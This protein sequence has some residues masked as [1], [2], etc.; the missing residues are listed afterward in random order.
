MNQTASGESMISR[1]LRNANP[2]VFAAYCIVAAFCTYFCMYAFRK[3]FTAG[4][5]ADTQLGGVDYKI[6]LV[7]TQVAG[8]TLSK[9]IGIK[10]VSELHARYRAIGIAVLIAVAEL[11]LLLF[12]ITPRPYNF[13]WL[14]FN[15]L[16]LGM[17]FGL[18]LGYLEGRRFTEALSAGLCASFIVSSGFVKSV[19]TYLMQECSIS[20]TWMPFVTGYVFIPPLALSVWL[21]A[22]I[23]PPDRH[24]ELLRTRREPM[25]GRARL[26]FLRR[27]WFGLSALLLIILMLTVVRSIRDD[28]AAEIWIQFGYESAPDVF[29]RSE[30]WVAVGVTLINAVVIVIG[31]NRQAFLCSLGIM[32]FGFALAGGS[33]F[34]YLQAGLSPFWFMVLLGLGMYIPYVAFHTTIYER[35]MAAF[36]EPGTIGYLMYLSDALGY[37]GFVLLMVG[38]SYTVNVRNQQ[39]DYLQLLIWVSM[40]VASASVVL[41]ILLAVYYWLRIPANQDAPAQPS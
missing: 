6:W 2:L 3:P 33:L 29:A 37:L 23:P 16:P 15:G 27:H 12:A 32:A 17:V 18:V 13:I 5:F 24:D 8:Y 19:A 25:D 21:L 31:D 38:N 28:F 7:A 1:Y 10:V 30:F 26:D 34:G 35:M 20:E 40:I 22:Q 14:F 4:T 36:R 9:F 41:T 11:A 39:V